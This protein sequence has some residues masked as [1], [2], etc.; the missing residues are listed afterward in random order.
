MDRSM[1]RRRFI[2]TTAAA[3]VGAVG[4]GRAEAGELPAK[5]QAP[6]ASALPPV[7]A[8][9]AKRL[10]EVLKAAR[11]KLYPRCRV[12]PECDGNACAGEVPGLGGIGTGASF[13]NNLLALNRIQLRMRTLHDGSKPELATTVLGQHLDLPVLCAS[14]G[15]T[16]Y[17]MGGKMSEEDFIAALLGG[18]HRAG[19]MGL[20]ADGTEDP[21]ETYKV[22][23]SAIGRHGRG[24]GVI[25]P[26]DQAEI[27]RRMR[28]V[29]EAGAVA[30]MVDVDSA[31]RA[32]RAAKLGQVIEPK[33][34][35]QLKELVRATR[36]PFVVKGIMTAD[37]A[38]LALE[39]GAAGIVVSNHG[40]RCLDHTPGTIEVL[41]EIAERVKGR[42]AVLADGGVRHGADVLK[43][44]ALGADAVL[45][46]RPVLRGA[47][48]AGAEGV[49]IILDKLRGELAESM[50]LTGT[51]S[52]GKV[53]RDILRPT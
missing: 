27:I 53:R 33:T 51:R 25:K 26:R 19:T 29:E 4:L 11:E 46:G 37:E 41:S 45:V 2:L 50:V 30:V 18:A 42:L 44:L 36:L 17:N 39:V 7:K 15:G 52:V 20:I 6:D 1:D 40:G 3:G 21:L 23:L 43:F 9:G 49:E 47:H 16:T 48:G 8:G 5:G 28:L 12:C 38:Q 32:A 10:E 13:K 14:L 24:I 22:R 34:P 31:G 35:A